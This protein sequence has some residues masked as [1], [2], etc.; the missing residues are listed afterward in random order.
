MRTLFA[1]PGVKATRNN[2]LDSSLAYFWGG[3]FM[4]E[5]EVGSP[6]LGSWATDRLYSSVVRQQSFTTDV[7]VYKLPSSILPIL[8]PAE[9]YTPRSSPPPLGQPDPSHRFMSPSNRGLS[10]PGHIS[11]CQHLIATLL[12]WHGMWTETT[13]ASQ[14]YYIDTKTIWAQSAFG[15]RMSRTICTICHTVTHLCYVPRGDPFQLAI[16]HLLWAKRTWTADFDVTPHMLH[17]F[18]STAV[19][20]ETDMQTSLW[21]LPLMPDMSQEWLEACATWGEVDQVTTI[22]MTLHEILN[23]DHQMFDPS[24]SRQV[25]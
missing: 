20:A 25:R 1:D 21:D 3:L 4:L 23:E 5:T 9:D 10:K 8:V 12:I 13:T 22:I 17:G 15:S 18:L 14:L 2:G 24:G 11:W 6:Y 16:S 19:T 7:N